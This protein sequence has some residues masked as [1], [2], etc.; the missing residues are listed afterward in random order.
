MMLLGLPTVILGQVPE[1]EADDPVG[2]IFGNE[3]QNYAA[4]IEKNR[5]RPSPGRGPVSAP[6]GPV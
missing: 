5:P 6:H 3:E 2:G 1:I 4:R